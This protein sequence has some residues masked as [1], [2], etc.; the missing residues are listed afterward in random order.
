MALQSPN[1]DSSNLRPSP[2]SS[3]TTGSDGI[4][5]DECG[6]DWNTIHD[7]SEAERAAGLSFSM[8]EFMALT[9]EDFAAMRNMTSGEMYAFVKQRSAY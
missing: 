5:Y 2:S 8:E 7:E 1:S 3:A 4:V 6:I 9:V